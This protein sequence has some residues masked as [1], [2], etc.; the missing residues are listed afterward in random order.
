MEE[1]GVDGAGRWRREVGVAVACDV[2]G[3]GRE[4]GGSG[5]GEDAGG[6]G[7]EGGERIGVGVC[8]D[9]VFAF[10]LAGFGEPVGRRVELFV[11]GKRSSIKLQ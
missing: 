9:V 6:G 11:S 2:E 1:R 5:G 10:T 7:C 4:R 3:A 8:I